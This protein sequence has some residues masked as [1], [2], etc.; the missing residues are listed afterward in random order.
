MDF[1]SIQ[2]KI[3]EDLAPE[4]VDQI[5]LSSVDA[6]LDKLLE[7]G[8]RNESFLVAS[9]E[10]R[11]DAETLQSFAHVKTWYIPLKIDHWT[12]THRKKRRWCCC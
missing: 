5:N 6:E 4:A 9:L 10:E 3:L 8:I 2:N 7:G 1:V 11:M 12:I